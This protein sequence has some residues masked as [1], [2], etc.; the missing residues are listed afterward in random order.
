MPVAWNLGFEAIEDPTG[1]SVGSEENGAMV[2]VD[3]RDLKTLM[4]K[5]NT[6]FGTDQS[7]GTSN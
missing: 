7:A 4:G 6:D 2:T 1:V 3:S 5:E